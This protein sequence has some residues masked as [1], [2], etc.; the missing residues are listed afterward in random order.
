[1]TGAIMVTHYMDLAD[2]ERELFEETP[3]L[4][5]YIAL[6]AYGESGAGKTTLAT[7][8]VRPDYKGPVKVVIV[9]CEEGSLS[10][11]GAPGTR[12]WKATSWLELQRIYY[13]LRNGKH[14]VETVSFDT[15]TSAE[16]LAIAHVLGLG[17]A[18]DLEQ[19]T[20]ASGSSPVDKRD[21]GLAGRLM[22]EFFYKVVHLK[23]KMNVIVTAHRKRITDDVRGDEF[24][25]QFMPSVEPIFR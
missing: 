20:T 22:E 23:D 19:L 21:Y 10:I 2:I 5:R 17:E 18:P 24:A 13:Y 8:T 9:D 15:A 14:E 25:P 12:V 3:T 11:V 16:R 1:M 4:G 6:G 7:T